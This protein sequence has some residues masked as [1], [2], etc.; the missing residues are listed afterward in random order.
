MIKSLFNRV[1]ESIVT[2]IL[3]TIAMLYLALG[4]AYYYAQTKD[5][6][7]LGTCIMGIALSIAFLRGL[8][9]RI[10]KRIK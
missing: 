2:H 5:T 4:S 7:F 8:Y 9:E 1:N 6:V 3:A 10:V